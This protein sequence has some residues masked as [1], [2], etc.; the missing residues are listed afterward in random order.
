MKVYILK[1]DVTNFCSF[2]QELGEGESIM[3]LSRAMKWQ[4]FGENYNEIK[5]EVRPNDQGKKNYGFDFSGALN[6]FFIVSE[7]CLSLI[8]DILTPRGE[9]LPVI[10]KSKRKKFFGY[11]P[12]NSLS[13]C[14]DRE[15]SEYREYPNGLMINKVVLLREKIKDEYI[16]SIDEDISK[17]FV[18]NKFKEL[19]KEHD[20]KGFDFS[21]EVELS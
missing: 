16:F 20:L 4:P 11:Y 18:T 8:G 7:K 14:F 5:L 6:P 13:G 15:K 1:S 9:V 12:T 21:R 10:T 2:I 19:I 17:V 3:G